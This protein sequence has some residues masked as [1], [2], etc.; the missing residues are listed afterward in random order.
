MFRT[1][2]VPAPEADYR[3]S[4]IQ[5]LRKRIQG[6]FLPELRLGSMFDR[7]PLLFGFNNFIEICFSIAPLS[8]GTLYAGLDPFEGLVSSSSE[9][10]LFCS[11]IIHGKMITTAQFETVITSL[12]STLDNLSYDSSSEACLLHSMRTKTMP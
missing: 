10:L 5:S 11:C 4:L 1:I 9:A 7:D 8:F 3:I 12:D 2:R 6:D